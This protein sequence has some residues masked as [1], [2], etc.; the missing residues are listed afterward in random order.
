MRSSNLTREGSAWRL[1]LAAVVFVALLVGSELSAS[2]IT[3]IGI[4][5]KADRVVIAVQGKCALRF[6]PIVSNSGKYVGFQFRGP[7]EIK[8][9]LVHIRSGGIRS[10][11][12]SNFRASP[13]IS[14]IVVN[15]V[16]YLDYATHWSAD[17]RRVEIH[18]MK[19]GAKPAVT[20][21]VERNPAFKSEPAG[22]S[23]PTEVKPPV[24]PTQGDIPLKNTA[25]VSAPID[26]E[27][28][29]QLR[30]ERRAAYRAIAAKSRLPRV[31]G[32]ASLSEPKVSLVPELP[33][34]QPQVETKPT[35]EPGQVDT[36]L[37]DTAKVAEPIDPE[38]IAQL[39]EERREAYR[40]IAAKLR[41]PKVFTAN[42]KVVDVPTLAPV[43]TTSAS[44]PVTAANAEPR[45]SVLGI[46][47][48]T[49]A[50]VRA[51]EP[52]VERLPA[53]SSRGGIRVTGRAETPR[54][55]RKISVNFLA[56]DINDVL[57]ALSVQSGYNIVAGKD[58]TGQVTVSL[59][60]VGL[61]EALDYVAKLSGYT[62]TKENDTYLVS[63]KESLRT[64]T[65]GAGPDSKTEIIK[66]SYAKADDVIA[67]LKSRFPD[68]AVSK[69]GVEAS[70]KGT[71]E[72]KDGQPQVGLKNNLL[73]LAGP[74]LSVKE[75]RALAEQF[76][77]TLRAQTIESTRS[78]YRVKFASPT[79]LAQTI[80][81]LVPGV[82]IVFAPTSDFELVRFKSAKATSGQ[83]PQVER[84]FD[85][86]G[87]SGSSGSKDKT[88][89][90]QGAG[91]TSRG[92]AGPV[93]GSRTMVIVGDE[94][95][96]AKAMELAAQLD[97]KAPQIKI[98][99]KITSISRNGEK[100]LGLT[101]KW[102]DYG[103]AEGF[104]DFD[105]AT[106]MAPGPQNKQ[107][108]KIP[109]NRMYRLPWNFSA[110]LDALITSGDAELLASPSIV[111]LERN[112]GVFFVGDEVTYIQRIEVTPTGQ[113][114][115]TDTKRVGV[116]MVVVGEINDDGYITLYLHPEVSTLKLSVEQGVTLPIVS[117]RFTDH[118]VR[119]KSGETIVIGGLI[120]NDE[121]EEMRKVPILGDLP[122][123]GHLFRH[124]STTKDHTE[125]VMF[126]T[127]STL[128]D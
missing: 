69:V 112:P 13:P 114:I 106:D 109:H 68:V 80:M 50:S 122:L 126:I 40:A 84:D 86:T 104:T 55:E 15:T 41:A 107:N 19:A 72:T 115:I 92:A 74:E 39:R 96:V 127:A 10:V 17:R 62:Y 79:Q 88:P 76:E 81:A 35:V 66:I 1:I 31:P 117:S 20:P 18:V 32:V 7:L 82:D 58:V 119:V 46:T 125:V 38:K 44:T 48:T 33:N 105:K 118:V 6:V 97:V 8:G 61:E 87:K 124:K 4:T 90:E 83:A 29:A 102:G 5:N 77:A 103:A 37:A 27:K 43:T 99:S 73:V 108:V 116:Q 67:L 12:Y 3:G 51:A 89:G 91:G 78:V 23:T 64:L 121:I 2:V 101:W 75:A 28:V 36:S 93:M 16:R 25:K 47:E 24:E 110:K 34:T 42:K 9:R 71:A 63:T 120:R 49:D 57:K 53:P 26:P 85:T 94:K 56:A 98:D 65:S 70:A 59:S 128:Q 22:V 95:S 113:N 14:R 111:C 123:L 11:K 54:N 52:P 30:E 45:V 21:L 60:N 100:A